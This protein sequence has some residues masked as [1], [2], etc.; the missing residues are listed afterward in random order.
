M[1]RSVK[2]V[3]ASAAAIFMC[4]APA[5]SSVPVLPVVESI[6]ASAA[7]YP[8]ALDYMGQGYAANGLLYRFNSGST[9]S[10]VGR[11]TNVSNIKVPAY[12]TINGINR[13]VT[14]IGA[15]A[16][17]VTAIDDH[18]DWFTNHHYNYTTSIHTV[19]MTDAY[20]LTEIEDR[21]FQYQTFSTLKWP[22][23]CHITTIGNSAFE[24]IRDLEA[25][26]IPTSVTQIRA[27]AFRWANLKDLQIP[28]GNANTPALN[29]GSLAF[30]YCTKFTHM[31]SGR[32]LTGS[33]DAFKGCPF[34]LR[35]FSIF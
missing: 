7:Q 23:N 14:K 9:V 22:T 8:V 13:A 18:P 29:F 15:G 5:I 6:T 12:V 19:D 33:P 34:A 17:R 27:Q 21:A 16:F 2:S 31:S 1:K 28:G 35:P 26:T 11:I 10:L 25:I 24:G 4:A 30:G 3:I 32:T 20:N